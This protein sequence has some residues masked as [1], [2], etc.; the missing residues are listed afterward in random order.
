MGVARPLLE[1]LGRHLEIRRK[2]P[3]MRP[4]L[5]IFLVALSATLRAPA[6]AGAQTC[7]TIPSVPYTVTQPGSY[8]LTGNLQT[9]IASG[10]AIS[11]QAD[12]VTIDLSGFTLQGTA[13]VSTLTRGV[14]SWNRRG[15]TVRNGTIAGF[16]HGILLD[17]N[18][19][20]LSRDHVVEK[21]L[22]RDCTY[23]GIQME[24]VAMILRES[25]I[26]DIGGP[27]GHHPNGVIACENGNGGSIQVLN[28]VV[29]HI[30]G[31]TDGQSPDGMMLEC[32]TTIAIG[33]RIHDV[34]DQILAVRGGVCRD[35][36]LQFVTQRP[37]EAVKNSSGCTL[38]GKTNYNYP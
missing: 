30:F 38:L 29:D 7:T 9:A 33:N 37:F 5:G 1:S 25:T 28:V 4:T 8:C 11:V 27:T 6:P 14:H 32:N 2:G 3:I 15:I 10:E 18:N 31:V 17:S 23:T 24:G 22:V 12:N 34:E 16:F 35:N 26:R 36:V 19:L 20:D 21:V 13:G